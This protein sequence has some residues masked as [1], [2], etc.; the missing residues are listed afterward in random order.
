M[1]SD[2]MFSEKEFDKYSDNGAFLTKVFTPLKLAGMAMLLLVC[3]A[4]LVAAGTGYYDSLMAQLSSTPYSAASKEV[5]F[6]LAR[7][8]MLTGIIAMLFAG[9][10][11]FCAEKASKAGGRRFNVSCPALLMVCCILTIINSVLLFVEGIPAQIEAAGLFEGE[12]D[13]YYLFTKFAP[14]FPFLLLVFM[15][16]AGIVFFTSV[17]RTVK[18]KGLFLTGAPMFRLAAIIS[19]V[20]ITVSFAVF[21]VI[22]LKEYRLTGTGVYS[23]AAISLVAVVSPL[24]CTAVYVKQYINALQN[25]ERT[26][27][28]TGV[29]LYMGS[30]GEASNYYQSA[31]SSPVQDGTAAPISMEGQISRKSVVTADTPAPTVSY[32]ADSIPEITMDDSVPENG[33]PCPMCGR[34]NPPEEIFC[35]ECGYKLR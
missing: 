28:M 32:S 34:K 27:N 17:I 25:A 10:I 12:T 5:S 13:Y 11:I 23:F 35:R 24:F 26:I 18:G 33:E 21:A 31:Y 30:A 16:V 3:G 2:F 20:T 7:G 4:V 22:T 29:N 15:S 14:F 19:G 1:N 6:I 9:G 8:V